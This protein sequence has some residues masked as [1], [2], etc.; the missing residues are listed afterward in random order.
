MGEMLDIKELKSAWDDD[1]TVTV[2]PEG[3]SV[4]LPDIVDGWEKHTKTFKHEEIL[5]LFDT[6]IKNKYG[7]YERF[8]KSFINL[9]RSKEFND[10]ME[11]CSW[12]LCESFRDL[13]EKLIKMEAKK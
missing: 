6:S 3:V 2:T 13:I 4:N 1:V 12:C 7:E 9:V 5:F 10:F 11:T 8:R